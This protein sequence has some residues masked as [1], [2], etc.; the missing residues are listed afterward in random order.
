MEK[1]SKLKT[2]Q[3]NR[4]RSRIRSKVVGTK[5]KPRMSVFKSNKFVYVQIIDDESGKTLMSE[6]TKSAVGKTELEKVRAL[7]E[8]LAKRAIG[9][10]IKAVVFDRGGYIY[11]GKIAE[12][13]AGARKGGLKF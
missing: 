8:N 12:L 4:R 2:V 11:T 7:G 9:H 5:E 3:R 6:S 1:K 13:A 10:G